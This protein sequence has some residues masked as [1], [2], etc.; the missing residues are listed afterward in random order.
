MYDISFVIRIDR[1]APVIYNLKKITGRE[2]KNQ[3]LYAVQK[4]LIKNLRQ[5]AEFA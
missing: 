4:I 2:E 3:M 1:D 5:S